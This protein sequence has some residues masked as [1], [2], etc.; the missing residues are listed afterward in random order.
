MHWRAVAFGCLLFIVPSFAQ[1]TQDE[2]RGLED[3]LSIGNLTI[4]DLTFERKPFAD[5]LRLALVD[6]ALD[7]PIE[8]ADRLMALHT[9]GNTGPI[10]RILTSV[11][12]QALGDTGP[13]T[14]AATITKAPSVPPEVPPS[15]QTPVVN[16]AMAILEADNQVARATERLTLDEKRLLVESMPAWAVEED[17][18]KFDFVKSKP[19]GAPAILALL[20]KVE[21]SR[22][23]VAAVE[24]SAAIERAL[25]LLRQAASQS[26]GFSNRIRVKV[27]G[28]DVVLAGAGND[29]HVD[30]DQALVID[31]GGDDHYV[32]RVG[33]GIG[34]TGVVIDLGG[35][36]RY[37]LADASLGCGI[38]GIGIARDIGGDDRVQGRSL[39]LGA[40]LAGVGVFVKEGGDRDSYAA[41]SLAEGFGQFGVG[42]MFDSRGDDRY[43]LKFFGQ[44]ASRT[45]GVGWLIDREG[46]DVYRAGGLILNSPLFKDVYYSFAQGFSSGYREDTG[47]TS[48]GIGLL[49]DLGGDDFYLGE[50]YMQAASYWFAIGSLYDRGGHD[51]YTGYHYCQA[52]A[53]HMTAAFLFDLAGDDG[54]LTKFGASHAIGHDYGVA[55]LLD[56]AGSDVYAAR[57]SQPGIGNANGLGIF[58]DSAGEDRYAGPPATGNAARGSGSLGVFCD[59]SGQD[60]YREGLTDG[61]GVFRDTWGVAYDLEDARA[62]AG[63]PA[64]ERPKPLVG[65]TPKPTDAELDAIYKK[66]TQWGVGTAADEVAENIDKL[67]A[68][69]LPAVEWMVAN[70]LRTATRLEQRAF[71]QVAAGIGAPAKEAI[72]LKIASPNDD[73]ARVA[74]MV[75][76]DGTFQEGAGLIPGALQRP[77]LL[78]PAVRAAGLLGAKAAVPDLLPL[79]ANADRILAL[80]AMIALAQLKD[81][82]S[83]A[84][85]RALVTTGELPI[86]K[87]AL[88]LM[89]GFPKQG[90]EA[91]QAM[92]GDPDEKVARLGIE[93]LGMIGTKEALGEIA[94]KLIDARPGVRIQALLALNGRCPEEHRPV[95]LSL[96]KDPIPTVR[97]VAQR[98]DPGR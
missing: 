38:L 92:A 41:T 34:R 42:L 79:C 75:C 28:L 88:S 36:D 73:E 90:L 85:A 20:A 78:R 83:I 82:S 60:K 68:I 89:A 62:A 5:P 18:I 59:L 57:D 39:C 66:A 51:T 13:F 61:Q 11:C 55:M 29:L 80:N 94:T 86:R 64:P 48:G 98:I 47:G 17:S 1:L 72:A 15:L 67:I 31:L 52:S 9:E 96:R 84:T 71:V 77:A 97:A 54:Y 6:L 37:D 25:P 81:E 45:Q 23:R 40:G 58:L 4:R 43:D 27:G 44:G 49:T 65:S 56:R 3:T 63:T 93:L 16:L 69:G 33:S 24:L 10:S 50:T 32:G 87:A 19:A 74:L 12:Q 2:R 70:K 53:M 21:V 7:R 91:G 22:I 14:L 8:A 95:L 26:G 46:S 30:S 35:D 76:I